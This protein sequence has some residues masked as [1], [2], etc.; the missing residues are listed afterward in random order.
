MKL[1]SFNKV[2]I[3]RFEQFRASAVRSPED[4][5]ALLEDPGLS[6][7]LSPEIEV[8]ARSFGNRFAAGEYLFFLFRESNISNLDEDRGIWAWLSAFYFDQLCP[9]GT[10]PGMDYRWVP[11]VNSFRNYY[12]HLLAGPYSIYR[13]HQDNPQLAMVCPSDSFTPTWRHC[14]TA[15]LAP[16]DRNQQHGHGCSDPP[17]H[18]GGRRTQAKS[19]R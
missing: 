19:G 8:E 18:R 9:D 1:R 5:H 16:R 3:N 6:T 12:R 17:L 2:G 4:L 10:S 14:G 7:T 11:S 13:A 15:G